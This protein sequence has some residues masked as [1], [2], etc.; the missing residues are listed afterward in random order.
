ML[1]AGT[2][3]D[4]SILGS[5]AELSRCGH[6]AGLQQRTLMVVMGACA[7]YLIIRRP[8]GGHSN[9]FMMESTDALELD[10]PPL[11]WPLDRPTFRC[12]LSRRFDE[13]LIE[14]WRTNRY[15][16]DSEI[17]GSGGGTRTRT[18]DQWLK[19]PVLCQL[20]YTPASGIRREYYSIVVT[21]S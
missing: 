3:Y 7:S 20:S 8:S 21:L 1:R 9:I 15:L 11:F 6:G 18:W 16:A 10:H 19:R 17:A 5:N 13:Q 14:K 12:V 4:H 2:D